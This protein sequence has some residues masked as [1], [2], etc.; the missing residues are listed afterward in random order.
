MVLVSRTQSAG[1]GNSFVRECTRIARVDR[2]SATAALVIG[3]SA[4]LAACSNK[5]SAPAVA[6]SGVASASPSARAAERSPYPRGR[7]RLATPDDLSR[8]VV[9]VSHL[10]IRHQSSLIEAPFGAPGWEPMPV[11]PARTA[12]QARQIAAGLR[13]RALE[14][15]TEFAE[16]ARRNSEDVVTSTRGGSLGAVSADF[17]YLYPEI[18]DA[19]AVLRVGEV[20]H[21]IETPY[22]F[23]LIQRRPTPPAQQLSAK[24]IVIG[25]DK[26]T[27]L[28]NLARAG[29]TPKRSRSQA[30]E[31]AR[32][33]AARARSDIGGFDALVQE[34][35]EHEDF[36]RNGRIGVWS[37]HD[38]R[39]LERER[40]EL[41]KLRVGDVTE[42]IDSHLGFQVLLR[43]E[44]APAREFAMTAIRLRYAASAKTDEPRSRKLVQQTALSVARTLREHPQRFRDFQTEYCCDDVLR[45]SEGHERVPLETTLSALPMGGIAA[46]PIDIDSAYLI[47]KRL[48]PEAA[49][50]APPP[51]FE[52]PAPEAPN[53]LA[54]AKRAHGPAVQAIVARIRDDGLK[55]L[56]LGEARRPEFR[57]VHDELHAA[58]ATSV[59][60]AERER[61]LDLHVDRTRAVLSPEE[62]RRYARLVQSIVT[63]HLM[64]K[65]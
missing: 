30:L 34:F 31:L 60:R 29:R 53:V 13:A 47:I 21:P 24:R 27:W 50:S 25:Y 36:S 6:G 59:S 37:V 20:S 40:E 1:W 61:V 16:L 65:R 10:L 56:D 26:A 57:K 35:S 4:G 48:S 8:T 62:Y 7:W 43:T 12:E 46:E 45:W 38:G 54:F 11:P 14:R 33:V 23:H 49:P 51:L 44:P 58:F 39:G 18:L 28:A 19:L 52:L 9:W 32:S 55:Q 64:P 3:A 41:A 22:G 63:E 5:P 2:W 17:F 42:P 15:P